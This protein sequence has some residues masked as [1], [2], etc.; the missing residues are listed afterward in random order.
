MMKYLYCP[1]C[2]MKVGHV[3]KDD[4]YVCNVC[5]FPTVVLL[6]VPTPTCPDC[7]KITSQQLRGWKTGYYTSYRCGYCNKAYKVR[8]DKED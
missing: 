2:D 4:V 1:R 8:E 7:S 3:L 6:D 5:G